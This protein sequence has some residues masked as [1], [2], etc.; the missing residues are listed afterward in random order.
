MHSMSNIK[1]AFSVK[2]FRFH[3]VS[4]FPSFSPKQNPI[5]ALF[6]GSEF[7]GLLQKCEM[8]LLVS[9]LLPA[10]HMELLGPHG[11]DFREC[12]IGVGDLLLYVRDN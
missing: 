8:R 12:C 4:P 1:F 3:L 9:P 10:I 5:P 6:A 11:T 2:N 7:Q